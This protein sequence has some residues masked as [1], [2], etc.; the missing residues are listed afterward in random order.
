MIDYR[1]PAAI[2]ADPKIRGHVIERFLVL[3]GGTEQW[4]IEVGVTNDDNEHM[5]FLTFDTAR[6]RLLAPGRTQRF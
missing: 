4:T 1:N 3:T 5:S 2:V 6:E